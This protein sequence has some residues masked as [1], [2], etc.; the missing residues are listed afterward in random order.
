MGFALADVCV[1]GAV[2]FGVPLLLQHAFFGY[3]HARP[4]LRGVSVIVRPGKLVAVI[5]PNGAGKSTLLRLL[6][7]LRQ[8]QTGEVLINDEQIAGIPDRERA[9]RLVYLPQQSSVAFD[10]TVEEVVA[11][12]RYSHGASTP[13]AAEA[14]LRTVGLFDRADDP[15][16]IL[17]AGQQ[18]RVNLARAIAQLGFNQAQNERYLLADEPVSAMDPH[19]A[20][21]SMLLLRDLAS[22]GI[23]VVVVLHDLSLALRFAD[24][25][26]LL[27]LEGRVHSCGATSDVLTPVALKAIFE[28]EFEQLNDSKGRP[29]S[30]VPAAG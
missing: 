21:A 1:A 18:Q 20:L 9:R 2:R 5:G 13:E 10:Y 29:A 4:V 17:S 11:M 14:S 28:V 15:F 23:G 27:D 3:E 30:F 6:A 26:V 7:G 12:G 25:V 24:E 8:P 22:R 19:Y 16:H